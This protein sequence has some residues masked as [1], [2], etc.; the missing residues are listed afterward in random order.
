MP[1]TISDSP[2]TAPLVL[3]G[4]PLA[5]LGPGPEDAIRR[6]EQ[7]LDR[8]D[9]LTQL[10]AV[11]EGY[12]VPPLDYGLPTRFKLSVV[13]PVYNEENTIRQLLSRLLAQPLP[14]EIII[15]DDHSLDMTRDVLRMIASLPN[16]S[17]IYK[18]RNEGK[19]AALRTG[20]ARATGDV[21]MIQDADLEYDP[22][23]IPKVLRPIV[24][25]EADV[26]YGSRFLENG[27][28]NS[29][30]LHRLGNRFLTVASNQL[31]GLSLTD[32]ETCYK[33][34]RRSV[35]QDLPLKQNRFGFEPEIT[36][37]LARRGYRIKEVPISY[38]AREFHEG[39]KIGMRD[40]LKAMWCIGRYAWA[41]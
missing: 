28:R 40:A 37:K 15:V 1:D 41:D 8:L 30:L 19:G 10:L 6:A 32:M 3:P 13:V 17:I 36:A 27:A 26:V 11:D 22:R 16:L 23:D 39:K 5:A 7:T 38:H 29:S 20:F 12:Q 2:N 31:T 24:E 25:D 18:D 4:K 21:V 35:I 34:F 33:V 14:M 9:D